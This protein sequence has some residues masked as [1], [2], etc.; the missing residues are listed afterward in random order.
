VEPIGRATDLSAKIKNPDKNQA[1]QAYIVYTPKEYERNPQQTWPLLLFLHGR[2]E[3]GADLRWLLKHGPL[4]LVM[5]GQDFSFLLIA[6]Q[7]TEDYLF[8]PPEFLKD[9]LD[10]VA[11]DY[12]VDQDRVYVTGLSMGGYGTWGVAMA[13]PHR[14]AAI[15]PIAGG[16]PLA[17]GGPGSYDPQIACGMK[18]L[19]VWA[20]HGA[21]DDIVPLA[22]GQQIVDE[23]K[24]CGGNV[25][26]TIYPDA[27]HE[28]SWTQ[29]Y[30]DPELY[31]WLL[32][33]SLK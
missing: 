15:A 26:L 23:L 9:V 18:H 7:I 22:A 31:E 33:H 5:Q 29:A 10:E 2:G 1:G 11:A 14:F 13:Y 16:N 6:P 21:K 30:S 3:R 28:G 17:F 27:D 25:R 20:F 8:F 32:Q 19:P 24:Q 4:K 12:R